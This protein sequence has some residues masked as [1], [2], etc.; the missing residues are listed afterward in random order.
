MDPSP[1]AIAISGGGVRVLAT[2]GHLTRMEEEGRLADLKVMAGASSGVLPCLLYAGGWSFREIYEELRQ[3]SE[4]L[5]APLKKNILQQAWAVMANY[6]VTDGAELREFLYQLVRRHVHHRTVSMTRLHKKRGIH[7]LFTTACYNTR[8]THVFSSRVH[9]V[10]AVEAA[11][12]SM[13]FPFVMEPVVIDGHRYVDGGL[14]C[15]YPLRVIDTEFPKYSERAIGFVYDTSVDDVDRTHWPPA[16]L[17]T[18]LTN[19]I[20]LATARTRA[21]ERDMTRNYYERTFEMPTLGVETFDQLT[22]EKAEELF[23]AG[24]ERTLTPPRHI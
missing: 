11:L 3:P 22:P 14:V 19:I 12:A 6:G 13:C 20:G 16:S 4:A 8:T 9:T 18:F 17:I 10:D 1:Q 5:K 7:V 15:N 2:I 24:Y 23:N 21:L